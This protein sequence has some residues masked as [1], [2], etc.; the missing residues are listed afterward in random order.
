M[1]PTPSASQ[2]PT[3]SRDERIREAVESLQTELDTLRLHVRYLEFDLEAT[4]RERDHAALAADGM[5]RQMER[6]NQI[7][8]SL[9]RRLP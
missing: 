4:R 5:A 9:K 8:A 1:N 6:Q 3:P 2:N 7:I